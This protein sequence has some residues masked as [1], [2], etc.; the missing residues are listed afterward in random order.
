[1]KAKWNLMDGLILLVLIAAVAAGGYLLRGKKAQQAAAQDTEVTMMVELTSKQKD[2]AELPKVGDA[3]II[4]E[5]EKMQT[6]VTDVTVTPAVTLSYDTKDGAVREGHVPDRYDIK[7]TL[8]GQGIETAQA[9]EI[10]GNAVRVGMGAAMK[11]K[12]W[13]GYGFILAVDTAAQ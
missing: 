13:A 9:V 11:S 7:L 2:F 5:K 10:N 12:N 4:G 1:M 3:V 6:R 8:E